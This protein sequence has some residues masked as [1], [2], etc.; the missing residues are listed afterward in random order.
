[1][2]IV[3]AEKCTFEKI[4]Q[5]HVLSFG[6]ENARFGKEI[7]PI[8]LILISYKLC[9][10]F[11]SEGYLFYDDNEYI[12]SKSQLYTRIYTATMH[13]GTKSY[14]YMQRLITK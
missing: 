12:A 7:S 8:K 1:M 3:W 13:N 10:K 5:T 6:I 4:Y 14:W 9:S 11:I 2:E